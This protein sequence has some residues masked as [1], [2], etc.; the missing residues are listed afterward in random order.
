MERWSDGS[1]R[2][3][4]RQYLGEGGG[5]M[6]HRYQGVNCSK[7]GRFVGKDGFMDG[8]YDSDGV[9]E[10]GYPLC[11]ECLEKNPVAKK[12]VL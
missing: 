4:G 9:Y 7:C 1:G 5:K 10:L 6:T 11:R 8:G 3:P 12:E 2:Q